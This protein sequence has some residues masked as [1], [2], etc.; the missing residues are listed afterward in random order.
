MESEHQQKKDKGL[1]VGAYETPVA[2][3]IPEFYSVLLGSWAL[4]SELSLLVQ[5]PQA[6][7]HSEPGKPGRYGHPH[8][9]NLSSPCVL[10][11]WTS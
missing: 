3:E 7:L 6:L 1:F 10:P 4:N 5:T 8:H 9:P 11:W 2:L